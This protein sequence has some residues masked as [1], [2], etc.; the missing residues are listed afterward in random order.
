MDI[1]RILAPTDFSL[2]S[3]PA[4]DYALGIAHRFGARVDVMNVWELPIDVLP[5]W[6]VQV[7]GDPPQAI[8]QLVRGRAGE[9]MELLVTE[10]RHRFDNVHGRLETGDP[11]QQIVEVASRDKYDLIVMGTHGRRGLS[12]LWTGSVAESV[13]RRATCPV[14]TVHSSEK[15]HG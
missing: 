13:V 10:L 12:H 1:K 15:K 3:R 11:G 14:L 7:P 4:L 2:A 8:T 9:Q 5:D 6:I